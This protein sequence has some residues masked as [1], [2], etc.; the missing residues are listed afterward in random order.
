MPKHPFTYV[1][2]LQSLSHPDRH[3]TGVTTDLKARLRKHNE[4]SVTHSVKYRPW[5]LT[6]AI[7]FR[8]PAKA[9][10]FEQYLKSGSGR[11]FARRHFCT[12]ARSSAE[13]VGCHAG[14]RLRRRRTTHA[15]REQDA[16]ATF[17]IP[18]IQRP[19][20]SASSPRQLRHRPNP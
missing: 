12:F 2:L 3:Y 19:S 13:S 16:P 7:A 4:G 11:E 9:R 15:A 14:V 6:T 1:Y 20:A 10:A 5:R 8:D 17:F 18:R